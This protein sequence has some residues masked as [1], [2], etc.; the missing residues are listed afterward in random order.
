MKILIILASILS[1]QLLLAFSLKEVC[2]SGEG[3]EEIKGEFIHGF[4]QLKIDKEKINFLRSFAL[5]TGLS[6]FTVVKNF[7]ND[8][9]SYKLIVSRDNIY[10]LVNLKV[11]ENFD[12]ENVQNLLSIKENN[13][14]DLKYLDAGLLKI[15]DFLQKQGCIGVKTHYYFDEYNNNLR[16]NINVE[17][18]DII[19]IGK[20]IFKGDTKTLPANII[21]KFL[22]YRGSNFNETNIRIQTEEARRY[23]FSRG[24]YRSG[25]SPEFKIGEN[26]NLR[27]IIFNINLGEK[28]NFNFKGN[29]YIDKYE[30][31]KEIEG[32]V[33]DEDQGVSRDFLRNVITEI[34]ERKGIYGS[35]I[36][37]NERIGIYKNDL[38]FLNFYINIK[39]GEKIKVTA[40]EFKGIS[41]ADYN[42]FK[43]LFYKNA[44]PLASNNY[45]DREYLNKFKNDIKNYLLANG[46]VSS[47]VGNPEVFIEENR[48]RAKISYEIR[49]KWQCIVS[50]IKFINVNKELSSLILKGMKNAIG[51]PLDVVNIENDLNHALD[52]VY[53]EGY[54]FANIKNFPEKNIVAYKANYKRAEIVIEFDLQD[55]IVF[56]SLIIKGNRKT[57]DSVI[58]R[59][60][61]FKKGDVITPEKLED[62][63]KRITSLDIFSSVKIVP[64]KIQNSSLPVGVSEMNL[65]IEVQEEK[66]GLGELAPGFR[67][68][69]G[70]KL[71]F[72]LAYRNLWGRN[73]LISLKNQVNR[74]FSLSELDSRRRDS[75]HHRIE[76]LTHLKY[77]WPYLTRFFDGDM[78]LSF[79]RRR[80]A[81]FD[82]DIW[83]ISPEIRKEFNSFFSSSLAYRFERI[84]QFDATEIKDQETFKIGGI[85]PA[86]QFDF[87]DNPIIPRSGALF[88]LSW[89]FANPYFLS[90]SDEKSEINFFKNYFSQSLLLSF[91]R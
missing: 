4:E 18:E 49:K 80:F 56:N 86:L 74:R 53:R 58:K 84:H 21:S 42:E 33:Q 89:E 25:I 73:H 30:I 82:A 2:S 77:T 32:S 43:Y 81:S 66:F 90:K 59:E 23:F 67:T 85:T 41:N 12:I 78:N 83:K 34:Y 35:S 54:L 27:N 79:Q 65:L 28:I 76:A 13:S 5:N 17:Y 57:K 1:H 14:I 87:R 88:S 20:V 71:S 61:Q 52:V 19:R 72:D 48:K 40:L 24:F 11:K 36:S 8:K 64:Y 26:A 51:R 10:K 31:L 16:I 45:L 15:K 91:A 55:K 47:T 38:K 46:H 62:F 63:R 7:Q 70:A 22:N 9:Y 39:E 50:D 6:K 29:N 60:N 37:I 68:D 44:T 3:C 75:G 69:L